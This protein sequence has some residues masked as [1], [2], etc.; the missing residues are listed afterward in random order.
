MVRYGIGS[1]HG[2][3]ASVIV[4]GSDLLLLHGGEAS[5]EKDEAMQVEHA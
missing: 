1:L 4:I 2:F 5:R 3:T